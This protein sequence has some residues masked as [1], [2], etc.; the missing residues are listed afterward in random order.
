MRLAIL[1][2]IGTGL[3][4]IPHELQGKE[5]F[6]DSVV[7][8]MAKDLMELD[9]RREQVINLTAAVDVEGF[10]ADQAEEGERRALEIADE[11]RK[12]S[13][14]STWEVISKGALFFIAGAMVW[15]LVR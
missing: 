12:I 2:A 3:L 9:V 5:C 10:R 14:P 7:V 8:Q 6:E 4:L 13:T 11:Y 1:F 15:E